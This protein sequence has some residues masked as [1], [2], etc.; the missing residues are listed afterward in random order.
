MNQEIQPLVFFVLWVVVMDI[1]FFGFL[2][3]SLAEKVYDW[4]LKRHL[5]MGG[6][7]K[8]NFVKKMRTISFLV[9]VFANGI[10]VLIVLG[11]LLK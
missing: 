11:V 3:G 7:T 5:M 4:R 10:F 1:V 2:R 9:L 8:E 6:V